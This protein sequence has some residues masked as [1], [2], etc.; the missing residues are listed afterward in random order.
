MYE[1]MSGRKAKVQ[2]IPRV[3]L[4]VMSYLLRPFHSG[5]SSIMRA[6]VYFDVH[7]EFFDMT[8]T[9]ERYPAELTT[10]EEWVRLRCRGIPNR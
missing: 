6:S 4:R 3:V 10:L 5:L 8:P 9:L 2:H 1:R 7:G